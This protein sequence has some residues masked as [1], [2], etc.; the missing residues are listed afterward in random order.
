MTVKKR[1]SKY[2]LVSSA[3]KVLGTHDTPRKAYAQEKAIKMSQKRRSR[4]KGHK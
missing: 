2:V 3:G 1:G 4:A